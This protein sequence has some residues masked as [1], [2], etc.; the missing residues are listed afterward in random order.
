M[1]TSERPPLSATEWIVA[2]WRSD[3]SGSVDHSASGAFSGQSRQAA[4][5]RQTVNV[6]RQARFSGTTYPSI[7]AIFL[8]PP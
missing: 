4:R 5:W 3:A 1:K 6:E 7:S 2:D 8:M